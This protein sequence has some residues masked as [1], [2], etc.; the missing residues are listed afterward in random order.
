MNGVRLNCNPATVIFSTMWDDRE[1]APSVYM[2]WWNKK[3][4][5]LWVFAYELERQNSPCVY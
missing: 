2:W 3:K 1:S 5:P 4:D